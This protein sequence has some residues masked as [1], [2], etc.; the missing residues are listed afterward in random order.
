MLP[1]RQSVHPACWKT[2]ELRVW[3]PQL[4]FFA[5]SS[6]TL[7]FSTSSSDLATHDETAGTISGA[8]LE[9]I[10]FPAASNSSDSV[11]Q[12]VVASSGVHERRGSAEAVRFSWMTLR[13]GPASSRY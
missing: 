12:R 10:Y 7:Y 4:N 5:S 9:R 6:C 3:M 8:V 1:F 13:W 11:L 2:A